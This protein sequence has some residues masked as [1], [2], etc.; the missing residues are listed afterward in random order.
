[1]LV[2]RLTTVFASVLVAIVSVAHAQSGCAIVYGDNWAFLFATPERWVSQC[3]A[4]RQ[5]GAALALWPDGTTFADAP[6]VMYVTV[7][8]KEDPSLE[9]FAA[10]EQQR[11]RAIAP[12]V[13]VMPAGPMVAANGKRAL[14]V[15]LSGDLGQNHELV[16]YTEGPTAYFIVVLSARNPQALEEHRPAFQALLQSFSPMKRQ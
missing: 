14:V 2:P 12:K 15:R 11:F 4:E 7:N 5:T 6:A 9:A 8:G 1:M 16:A 13:K 3:R 10:A